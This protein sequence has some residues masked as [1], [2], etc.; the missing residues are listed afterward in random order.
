MATMYTANHLAI[1]GIIALTESGST[2]IWMSRIRSGIPIYGLSGHISSRRK[3][4]LYRGVYPIEFDP[5]VIDRKQVTSEAIAKLESLSLVEQGDLIILTKG[6]DMGDKGGTNA[7]K[8]VEV[9]KV[10]KG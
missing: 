4:T 7:L 5:T 2:T 10:A 8:I 9:G 3:M 6:S 1:K